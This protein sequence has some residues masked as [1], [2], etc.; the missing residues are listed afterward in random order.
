M[1][2]PTPGTWKR[3]IRQPGHM[4]T[5][6]NEHCE[7][8]CSLI[9]SDEHKEANATL[10]E[11]APELLKRLQGLF[12]IATHPKAKKSEIRMIAWEARDILTKFPCS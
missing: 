9:G 3:I 8:V 4:L 5:I 12:N 6:E 11:A 7:Y 2:E 1:N 10:I